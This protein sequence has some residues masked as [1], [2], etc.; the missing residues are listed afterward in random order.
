MVIILIEEQ[1]DEILVWCETQLIGNFKRKYTSVHGKPLDVANVA[2]I[3]LRS[4]H[5]D[6]RIES[7]LIEPELLKQWNKE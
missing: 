3:A 1:N 6:A 7:E 5:I 2:L 4:Q